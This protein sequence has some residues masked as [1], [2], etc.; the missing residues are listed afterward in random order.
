MS[1][2]DDA[3]TGVQRSKRPREDDDQGDHDHDGALALALEPNGD[4]A[5]QRDGSETTASTTTTTTADATSNPSTDSAANGAAVQTETAGATRQRRKR[6]AWDQSSDAAVNPS[7]VSGPNGTSASLTAVAS[8]NHSA[9]AQNASSSHH[10]PLAEADLSADQAEA[11]ERARQFAQQL[12]VQFH[13]AQQQHLLRQQQLQQEQAA[14]MKQHAEAQQVALRTRAITLIGRVYVGSIPFEAGEREVRAAMSECGPIRSV[15]FVND[16]VAPTR[17]KGFGFVEYEYPESGD[18]VLSQMHHARIGDRQLKFG[19]PNAPQPMQVLIEELRKEGST[20]PHVFVA[21]IHPEL[22]ESDIREVFQSFGPVAYC[23]LMVDLVTGRH[24]GCGYVQFESLQT[25]KDAIAALNR[26]DLGGLLLHVVKGAHSPSN[27]QGLTTAQSA[28]VT[29]VLAG[30]TANDGVLASAAAQAAAAAAAR[31]T[32]ARQESTAAAAAAAAPTTNAQAPASSG[33][34]MQDKLRRLQSETQASS[35]S[36]RDEENVS[37]KGNQ[38]YAL[39]QKLARG[40]TSSHIVALLNMIDADEID[41]MLEQEVGGECSNFGTV[42][43]VVVHVTSKN[44]VAIFVQFAQLEEADAAVLALNNRWFGGRQVRAQLYD[45]GQ[46]QSR[47]L[48]P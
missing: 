17:H 30:R 1:S 44:D 26:L 7:G 15:S 18:I 27:I 2:A 37:I 40:T 3:T 38:V 19:T 48:S 8:S 13:A 29:N 12:T 20:F 45:E 14:K 5:A 41:S 42:E 34:D 6:A 33:E 35:A 28:Q 31:I 11:L 21:N 23:I 9:S 36:L 43:R 47:Q 22:S 10:L 24:K 4:A 16:P 32:A 25:A 39:M 46:F